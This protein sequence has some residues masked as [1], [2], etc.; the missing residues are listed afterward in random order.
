MPTSVMPVIGYDCETTGTNVAQDRIVS[1]ALVARAG[2]GTMTTRTWLIDPG[3]EVPPAV[4]AIHGLTTA[5]LRANGAPPTEALDEIAQAVA[6]RLVGGV[7][8][9]IFNAPFDLRILGAELA[10]YGLPSLATRLGGPVRPVIDPLVI[11]RGVDRYR[12]GPRKLSDLIGTYEVRLA[13]QLHDATDDVVNEIAVFDAIL[14][15]HPEVPADAGALHDWQVRAHR[16]W[17]G[18]FNKYLSSR[19]KAP[20]A[21]PVWP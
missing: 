12:K 19:G 2:D 17:A 6:A 5:H 9:L 4:V 7:P 20:S 3:V 16:E 14:R 11:D 1:A 15:A 8:L 21:D 18:S 10:R 13:G